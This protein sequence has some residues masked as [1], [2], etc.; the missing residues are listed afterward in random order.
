MIPEVPEQRAR[1]NNQV[2][3]AVGYLQEIDT[4]KQDIKNVYEV[5]KEEF[6]SEYLKS[7]K[8]IVKARHETAKLQEMVAKAELALAEDEILKGE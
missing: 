2:E 3:E 7:F 8:A 5:V 6:D 1:F 4:L